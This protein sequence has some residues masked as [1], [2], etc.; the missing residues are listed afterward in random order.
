V[1]S[2][3]PIVGRVRLIDMISGLSRLPAGAVFH[4]Q[5]RE[6][7]EDL[8]EGGKDAFETRRNKYGF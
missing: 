2:G 1:V 8:L 3:T 6:L 7:I 4:E 5:V